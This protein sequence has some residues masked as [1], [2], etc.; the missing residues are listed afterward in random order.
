MADVV[1]AL[2]D[3]VT[4]DEARG[5]V[6]NVGS[7]EEIA[8]LELARRVIAIT[9]SSS[10]PTL[11]PYEVAYGEGFEDMV[12]RVPDTS[13]INRL[14]GWAPTRSLDVIIRDVLESQRIAAPV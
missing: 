2:A 6:F 10:E 13:K 8:I 3:I 7:T 12:R 14:T 4:H 11:I 9:G 5:E 1:K